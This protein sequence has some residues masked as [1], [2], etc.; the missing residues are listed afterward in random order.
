MAMSRRENEIK[1]AFPS[2]SAAFCALEQAG[3]E[4]THPR[5]FEDNVLYDRP[6]RTI[7]RSGQILRL[8]VYGSSALLT[9]KGPPMPG[10]HKL[11]PEHEPEVADSAAMRTILE[12]LG[13]AP[14]YRYQKYR[15]VFRLGAL[16]AV[17]DETPLGAFVELE[18]E[19]DDV[20][21]R[22]RSDAT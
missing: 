2:A 6:D 19:P 12:T 9:L 1:L 13:Y 8:R 5:S 20:D 14:V 22:S 3:A 21:G 15:T 7:E 18:G 17:V 4:C 11:R 16:T 10:R